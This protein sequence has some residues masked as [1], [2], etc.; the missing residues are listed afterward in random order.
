MIIFWVLLVGILGF[1]A[2]PL[3]DSW[4]A[5]EN[6]AEGKSGMVASAHPL[7]SQVGIEILKKGG[8]AVDAAVATAFTLGVVEPHA[9]GIGGGGFMSIYLAKSRKVEVIDYRETAPRK[10]IPRLYESPGVSEGMATGIKSVAVPGT[11]AGLTLALKKFGTMNLAEVLLPAAQIAEEG[12]KVSPVLSSLMKIHASRLSTDPATAR[13]FLK[14]GQPF[15]AG[16]KIYL[17]DLARTYRRIAEKGAELFYGGS[18]ADALTQEMEVRADGWITKEDLAGYRPM[19]RSPIKGSYRGYEILAAPPTSGAAQVVELLNILEGFDMGRLG[20]T[21]TGFQLIAEAQKRVTADRAK[22][23]GDPDFSSVPLHGLLSKQYAAVLREG[24]RPGGLAQK[25]LPGN[26]RSYELERTS[27]VSVV[28]RERNVVA[29]TQTINSFFGSGVV[30]P[31]T[32]ILLNNEM[33]EFSPTPGAPNS[34]AP[35]KRPISSMSP[36]LILKDGRPY[37]SFGSAGATRI[38]SAMTQVLLNI[39]ESKMNIQ[40]AI[41][42]PRIHWEGDLFAESPIAAD[43]RGEL[44]RMGYRLIVR[45]RY[46]LF[47]GGVQGILIDSQTGALFGGAD[48]RRDGAAIGY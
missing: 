22:Y 28:D 35:G 37:L 7:A 10:A 1:L 3:P 34:L 12:F 46:D 36:M 43:V 29:L 6:P 27:H 32:G 41:N 11:L 45:H 19:E 25:V 31:G 38:I 14:N 30:L 13:I 48:P 39:V 23:M 15:E 2:S 44:I 42:A 40:R 21:A 16:E 9:S 18:L 17:K 5:G 20:H 4:A 47:S 8:N 33:H 26:P 24:I